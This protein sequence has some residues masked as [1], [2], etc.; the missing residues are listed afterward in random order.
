VSEPLVS[1]VIPVFNGARFLAATLA[2]VSAQDYLQREL[3]VVDDGSDDGS[4]VLAAA[5]PGAVVLHQHR[6]GPAAARNAGV[7]A[8]HGPLI[9]FLDQDDLWRPTKLS[10]QVR[11]MR[12]RPELGMSI[13]G[14]RLFLEPGATRPGW[15]RREL[16]D[17]DLLGPMPSVLMVTRAAF[18]Q[19][20]PF[21]TTN[22]ATSDVDWFLR[23]LDLGVA[24]T[25]IPDVLLD[26]RV[27]S[28]N[29]S[30]QVEQ[31]H[32][33]MLAAV[34]RSIARKRAGATSH[35]LPPPGAAAT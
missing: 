29:Q 33:G 30:A 35:P 1:V 21:D 25:A 34:R 12:A 31:C 24:W 2:S 16:L 20:G 11:A 32:A 22:M 19:I 15:L 9:A 23:A 5:V 28:E 14:H 13:T 4:A 10:V 8:A 7:A 26:K 18:A 17:R 3:L 27:H 6:Q